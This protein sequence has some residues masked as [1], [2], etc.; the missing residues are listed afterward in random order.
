MRFAREHP[1][2][3]IVAVVSRWA[4]PRQTGEFVR[5][6]LRGLRFTLLADRDGAV[7]QRLGLETHPQF[8]VF[9]PRGARLGMMF[10][11]DAALALV[12][13]RKLA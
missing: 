9:G 5:D 10:E 4:E 6:R 12:R 1:K 7:A 11:L 8:L 2:L 3:Q 13:A